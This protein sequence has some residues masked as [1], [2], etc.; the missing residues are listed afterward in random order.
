MLSE[1]EA[2]GLHIGESK[3]VAAVET[4]RIEIYGVGKEGD[5]AEAAM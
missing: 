4:L 5:S 1:Q 3:A 2:I